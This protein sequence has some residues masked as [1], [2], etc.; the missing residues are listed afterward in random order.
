M[1]DGAGGHWLVQ[2]EWRPAGWLVSAS[3]NLPLHHKVSRKSLLAPAHPNGPGKRAVKRLWC[4]DVVKPTYFCT[5]DACTEIDI[6]VPKWTV[7]IFCMYWKWLYQYWHS[8]YQN[9]LYRKTYRKYMY[10]NCHVPEATCPL[11]ADNLAYISP[12]SFHRPD[13]LPAAQPTA[14][15]H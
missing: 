12:L 1:G 15:K 13:S 4:G 6:C 10:K 7:L 2:M 11:Q 9:W 8:M 3:V 14:S 5:E